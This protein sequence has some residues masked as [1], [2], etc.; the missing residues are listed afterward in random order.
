VGGRKDIQPIPLISRGCLH[1]TGGGGGPKEELTQV[2][3][4]NGNKMELVI[5][6]VSHNE[7]PWHLALVIST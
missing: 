4:E 7:P 2:H 1:T 6:V 5:V 3:L